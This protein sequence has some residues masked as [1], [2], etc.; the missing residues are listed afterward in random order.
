EY[1]LPVASAQVKSVL[2]L[3][4]LYAEG[5]TTLH[6]PGPA[7]DH[8]ERL[9]AAMGCTLRMPAGAP[10]LRDVQHLQILPTEELAPLQMEVPGDFSSAAFLAVAAALVA[11][12]EV[13]VTGVGLNPTRSGLLKV[14]QAME[15]KVI[16]GA[17][18]LT[19]GEPVG[20]LT[21]QSSH[22]R[23]V[24]IGGEVVVRMIDELPILAVAAT[25]AEG[26]T[27]V[28]DA[29]ELR[30]KET[31]RITTTVEQLRR[32]GADIKAQPDGFAVRGPTPL[33]GTRVDSHGDHRLAMALAIAGLV[34]R[35]ETVVDGVDCIAD[36]FPGFVA[37]MARLGAEL[38]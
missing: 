18:H 36:S 37:T 6:V 31:D 20:D 5:P 38:R 32:M 11:G 33:V 13:T 23:G 1:S 17:T 9:L 25:Q 35:G 7:R 34:A 21:I 22:L 2:L 10:G 26:E 4:G 12:S 15:A 16:S 8:T 30:V 14:L 19:S 3:A 28:C 24:E 29:A 27:V